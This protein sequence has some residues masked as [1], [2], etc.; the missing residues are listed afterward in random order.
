M[1]DTN[2]ITMPR[3]SD[4]M[5]E[6]TIL[7]WLIADGQRVTHGDELVEI[8]TD[9][10]TVVHSAE[11]DGTLQIIAPEGATL[12]VGTPIARVGA[13]TGASA[14]ANG[15]APANRRAPASRPGAA[16]D[17][18][19]PAEIQ[20]SLPPTAPQ[21]PPAETPAAATLLAT[22]LARRA[23]RVHEIP[24]ERIAG[25][26]PR[27][28][29]TRGDVLEAADAE[30]T[31]ARRSRPRVTS[32]ASPPRQG[33]A[34]MP[35]GAASGRGETLRVEPSRQQRLIAR[36]MAEAKATIP[37][38]QVQAEV[39]MDAALTLRSDLKRSAGE[40]TVPSLNDLIVKACALALREHPRGNGSYT[41]GGFELHSRINVGVAVASE[42]ALVV[43]VVMDADTKP[44][45]VIAQETRLLAE[46]VRTGEISPPELSGATFTVSNLGMFGMSAITPVVNPPQA[47][48]LGVGAL[49]E[50]L[51]RVDGEIVDRTLM[52]LTLSCDHRILYGAD[53]AWLLSDVRALLEKPLGLL[54]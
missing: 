3:L 24:L 30:R 46:R 34:T 25:S 13:G 12:P 40:R 2:E 16:S 54:L 29:I 15:T 20:P 45:G 36:R 6:G 14:G 38:F 8:E 27:G 43:P 19:A 21:A 53:A 26:G 28:R 11:A 33:S 35:T 17:A 22:P 50:T 39:A 42:D 10:A 44:L 41:D 18:P 49:R 32:V 47:A 7:K 23:A 52:T 48:I 9:K 51:A 5:E 1:S 31:P 37:H 4:S